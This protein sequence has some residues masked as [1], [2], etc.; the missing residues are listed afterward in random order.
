MDEP[1]CHCETI[2]EF[3]GVAG[4]DVGTVAYGDLHAELDALMV[5]DISF[6][7]NQP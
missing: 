2:A 3:M 7:E 1:E 6:H 5:E 4:P